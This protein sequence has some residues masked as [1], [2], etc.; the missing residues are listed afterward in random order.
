MPFRAR[1]MASVALVTPVS[2]GLVLKLVNRVKK[3]R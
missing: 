2:T 3:L 1:I